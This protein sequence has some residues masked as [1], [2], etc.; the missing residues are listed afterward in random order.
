MSEMLGNTDTGNS[1][2]PD[3]NAQAIAQ[4]QYWQIVNKIITKT[5]LN[6][7]LSELTEVRTILTTNVH[8]KIPSNILYKA[9]Q[10]QNLKCFSFRLAVDVDGAAPTGYAPAT[11]EWS[12]S[13]LPTKLR[14]ILEVWR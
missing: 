6:A 13:F 10:I 2:F 1:F 8:V 3:C 12:T 11:S 14:L 5:R 7:F 9:R 4:S